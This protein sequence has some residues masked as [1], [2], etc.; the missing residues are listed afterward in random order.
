MSQAREL[1]DI[2]SNNTTESILAGR[3]NLI[4][5]G[6]FDVWQR[7]ESTSNNKPTW[8]Y[9]TADRVRTA[10]ASSSTTYQKV[11]AD[12][13]GKKCNALRVGFGADESQFHVEQI[14]E[15][16]YNTIIGNYVTLS[17]WIKC[18][19]GTA[20]VKTGSAGAYISN[21]DYDYK[22]TV[23]GSEWVKVV[24][25]SDRTSSAYD[26]TN[27][28]EF[29][30]IDNSLSQGDASLAGLSFDIAQVQLE[31]GSQATDFEY[32]S[33][34]EELALCQRYYEVLDA[35]SSFV[36]NISSSHSGRQRIP[37]TVE[38]RSDPTISF[39]FNSVSNFQYYGN[40][41]SGVGGAATKRYAGITY[42]GFNNWSLAVGGC[43]YV[44]ITN[45]GSNDIYADAEL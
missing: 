20:T 19:N 12:I 33:Y 21:Q 27:E 43:V 39:G 25:T 42:I 5:N 11:A 23:V 29:R 34:G 8:G 9:P 44:S 2:A 3:K 32:R 31:I 14:L 41:C 17:Y 15:N 28:M 38:K 1:A 16:S 45:T 7:G 26:G 40:G 13:A 37:F 30:F 18:N 4:I 36:T 35:S 24:L 6:G 22:E 10:C